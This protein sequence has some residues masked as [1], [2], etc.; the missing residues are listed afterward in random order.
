MKPYCIHAPWDGEACVWTVVSEDVP[1]LAAESLTVE[2][3]VLKLKVLVPELLDAN[4]IA[5]SGYIPFELV[6]RCAC[7]AHAV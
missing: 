2:A 4:G 6:T 1:G 3:L 7:V 5:A